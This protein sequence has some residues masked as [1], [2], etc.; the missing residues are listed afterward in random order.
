MSVVRWQPFEDLQREMN[1]IVRGSAWHWPRG[2]DTFSG[3]LEWRPSS[4]IT[5]TDKEYLIH[6]ELPG[7]KKDDIRVTVDQGTVT[8]S[9]ER[10]TRKESKDEKI[11]RLE[12]FQGKF[13]RSFSLPPDVDQS[14]IKAE[15]SD[16]VLALHLPKTPATHAPKSVEVKVT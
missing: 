12:S 8:F 7:V 15:I 5:E 13:A 10:K 6:A 11:H 2:L 1:R 4:D 14:Q 3:D 9:G 16:G